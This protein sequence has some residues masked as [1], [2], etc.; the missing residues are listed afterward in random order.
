MLHSPYSRH[1]SQSSTTCCCSCRIPLLCNL[2]QGGCVVTALSHRTA[3]RPKRR[4]E[5][6][7]Y[8]K[9]IKMRGALLCSIYTPCCCYPHFCSFLFVRLFSHSGGTLALWRRAG[10]FVDGRNFC[11]HH[12]SAPKRYN[13]PQ[14]RRKKIPGLVEEGICCSQGGNWNN[15]C[16]ET[17]LNCFFLE[18][19]KKGCIEVTLECFP[20][21]W[22][23]VATCWI[24]YKRSSKNTTWIL[25]SP[26]FEP[27]KYVCNQ[28]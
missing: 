21:T 17:T 27:L 20:P 19:E 6:S 5:K 11:P 9:R 16:L 7:P 4:E 26:F 1:S 2:L 12:T 15:T 10:L 24:L 3:V 25:Y 28:R 8:Y 13:T 14:K 22:S 18:G 23:F